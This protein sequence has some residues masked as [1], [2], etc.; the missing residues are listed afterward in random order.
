M[1]SICCCLMT[2]YAEHLFM[3]L[4]GICI[5]SLEKGLFQVLCSFLNQVIFIIKLQEFFYILDLNPLPALW[6]VSIFSHSVDVFSLSSYPPLLQKVFKFGWSPG[7][8]FLLW[9]SVLLRS[10]LI[11]HC[12]NKVTKIYACVFSYKFYSFSS[13]I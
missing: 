8:L 2:N 5:S 11:N 9:C 3:G 10:H 4:F 13:Y 1:V 6:F 12:L 7:Y